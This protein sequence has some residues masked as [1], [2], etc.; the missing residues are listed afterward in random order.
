[1][2]P[3]A[4]RR[5]QRRPLTVYSAETPRNQILAGLEFL[6]WIQQRTLSLGTVDQHS[7]DCWLTSGPTRR[8]DIG[9]FIA[10][11]T[12]RHLSANLHIPRRQ[13]KAAGQYLNDQQHAE[14]LQR[15]LNDTDLPLD[16][17]LSGA[18]TL[19]FGLT[20]ARSPAWLLSTSTNAATDYIYAS[21]TSSSSCHPDSPPWSTNSWTTGKTHPLEGLVSPERNLR[22]PTS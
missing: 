9:A 14:Q 21:A 22:C 19:L 10:W 17:R 18:L 8:Y 11:T 1:M 2:L 6:D 20:M 5:A 4:R 12:K 15:C 13:S 3:K 16:V 7:L